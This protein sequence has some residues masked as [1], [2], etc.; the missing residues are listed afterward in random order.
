[1]DKKQKIFTH[2]GISQEEYEEMVKLFHSPEID[3]YRIGLDLENLY[4]YDLVGEKGVNSINGHNAKRFV[5]LSK[6][7]F[8]DFFAD[9]FTGKSSY[10]S[11]LD[12]EDILKTGEF[13]G[14]NVSVFLKSRGVLFDLSQAETKE[15]KIRW[16]KFN[17]HSKKYYY[18]EVVGSR[19]LNCLGVKTVYNKTLVKNNNLFVLSLD[20]I[21]PEQ[22][23]FS[24]EDI[25]SVKEDYP[26]RRLEDIVFDINVY[27]DTLKRYFSL[28]LNNQTVKI[29]KE[30][31]VKDYLESYITKY[32][33][34]GDG[35]FRQCNI[36]WIYD[37]DKNEVISAPNF[38]YE[39]LCI[40]EARFKDVYPYNIKYLIQNYP[41][42]IDNI[43]KKL[44]T[45][46]SLVP[47]KRA[48]LVLDEVLSPEVD[49]DILEHFVSFI[50]INAK[51]F[52]DTYESEKTAAKN[53]I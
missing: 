44:K 22:Y 7:Y 9:V 2:E 34:L 24:L 17:H 6:D 18:S 43:V 5:R 8:K 50:K 36:G 37:K 15:D 10:V 49:E 30:Q 4:E 31:L 48:R 25:D 42:V 35:D 11:Y 27:A 40:N 33:I 12:H 23:Y 13:V 29:D 1:M 46:M 28:S 20:F 21:K 26:A 16:I 41:E 19:I 53:K 32:M 14:E 45:L 51:V 38:D 39:F 47:E 52:I 3:K